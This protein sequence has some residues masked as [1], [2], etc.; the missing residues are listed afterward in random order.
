MRNVPQSFL[1]LLVGSQVSAGN[2]SDQGF[3]H[4]TK[5]IMADAI[6]DPFDTSFTIFTD[7][8]DEDYFNLTLGVSAVMK[9]GQLFIDYQTPLGLNNVS[10]HIFALGGRIEF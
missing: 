4:E 10:S 7:D 5:N 1:C 3:D 6:Q 9:Q 8:P 2:L